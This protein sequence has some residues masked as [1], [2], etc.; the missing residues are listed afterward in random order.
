M[1]RYLF[2]GKVI[3]SQIYCIIIKLLTDNAAGDCPIVLSEGLLY[4]HI[5]V[6]VYY[7]LCY[8]NMT[9]RGGG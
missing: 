2:D 5:F 1:I 3:K 4:D 7:L 9:A 8:V 6:V